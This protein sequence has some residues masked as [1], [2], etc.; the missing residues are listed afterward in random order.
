M[1]H[2]TGA[3]TLLHRLRELAPSVPATPGQTLLDSAAWDAFHPGSGQDV[4]RGRLGSHANT[5]PR[6]RWLL[7]RRLGPRSPPTIPDIFDHR[8]PPASARRTSRLAS[9]GLAATVALLRIRSPP[10]CFALTSVCFWQL[11][12]PRH[13]RS[14]PAHLR[15]NHCPHPTLCRRRCRCFTGPS[16]QGA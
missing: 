10:G 8:L 13:G 1:I 14:R 15:P 3:R 11:P 6:L 16:V 9:T 12:L 4:T 2:T 7:A 5:T